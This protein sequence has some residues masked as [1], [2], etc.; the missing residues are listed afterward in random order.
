MG[1]IDLFRPKHRHSRAEVRLEAVRELGED[2]IATLTEIARRDPDMKI[3]EAALRKLSDPSLLNELAGDERDEALRTFIRR[4][5]SELSVR[6]AIEARDDADAVDAV[7]RVTDPKLL[8]D[9]VRKAQSAAARQRAFLRLEDARSLVGVAQKAG[10][11]QL[12]A[13]AVARISEPKALRDLALGEA[14]RAIQL[15]AIDRLDDATALRAVVERGKSKAVRQAAKEKLVTLGAQDKPADKEPKRKKQVDPAAE[16][17]LK[18]RKIEADMR[19]RAEEERKHA[20][21]EKKAR[22]EAEHLE[23]MQRIEAEEVA[24][25]AAEEKRAEEKRA[26]D[27]EVAELARRTHE[28]EES[29]EE[30]ERRRARDAEK[31]ARQAEKEKKLAEKA[32]RAKENALQLESLAARMEAMAAAEELKEAGALL[33]EAQGS[34]AVRGPL[35]SGSEALRARFDE[36]RKR[37]A[38]RLN[39]VRETEDWRRFANVPKLEALITR[40]ESLAKVVIGAVKL[41]EGQE[42]DAQKVARELRAMQAEWK[43]IGRPPREKADMMW[44][45]F[46]AAADIIYEGNKKGIEAL[47]EERQANLKMKEELCDKVEALVASSEAQDNP[48]AVSDQL[49]RLQE[50][51]KGIGPVP[52]SDNERV[53]QRF[54]ATLDQFFDAR[55]AHHEKVGTE[56]GVVVEQQLMLVGRAEALRDST[57]YKGAADQLK[58]LQEQWKQLGPGKKPESDEAWK[59]F[60]AACDHFFERRKAYFAAQDESRTENLVKKEALVARAEQLA[61]EGVKDADAEIRALMGEWKTIGSVSKEQGDAIWARFGKALDALRGPAEPPIEVDPSHGKFEFG[62]LADKLRSVDAPAAKQST[63]DPNSGAAPAATVAAPVPSP[64]PSPTPAPSPSPSPA[65]TESGTQDSWPAPEAWTLP[66]E[67]SKG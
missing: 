36:A 28:R 46:K 3:R 35:P 30:A 7:D 4:R 17:R 48:K 32:E 52:R 57:D 6:R 16:A 13:D 21:Q 31:A 47:D 27:T 53:W 54:R 56:R 40:A 33:K 25:K 26:R 55:K 44:E 63:V 2:E 5:V 49:K 34:A 22:L 1:F 62:T 38:G 20:T 42:L 64:S 65:P 67:P 39:E 66:D 51:W 43:Q 23:R 15:L 50:D 37:L 8:T 58:T 24:Q 41:E 59:K 14:T 10:D 61:A 11:P 29:S 60:R 12:R 18:Q 45:R 9:I 19:R